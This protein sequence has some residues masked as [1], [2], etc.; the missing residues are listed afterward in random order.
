M[1]I[2]VNIKFP[3][4]KYTSTYVINKANGA[5]IYLNQNK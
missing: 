5:F 4:N 3:E 1:V 2:K